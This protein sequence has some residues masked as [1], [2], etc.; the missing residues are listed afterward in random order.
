MSDDILVQ[1]VDYYRRRAEEYDRT[2]YPDLKASAERIDR[3]VA[4]LAPAGRI[5]EL[6]CGTGMWTRALARHSE[7]VTALDASQE[8]MRIARERCPAHV[9]FEVAD[10]FSWRPTDEFDVVFFGFWLSH[11]PTSALD[12]FLATATSAVAPGGRLL[13]VDEHVDYPNREMWSDEPEIAIRELTDGS[14]HPMVKVF[15]D[16]GDLQARLARLGWA[17]SFDIDRAWLIA[18]AHR[19]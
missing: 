15:L 13:F 14:R 10:L 12:A 18:S 1:Q 19:A 11:V 8:P 5:L 16:P 6:A 7:Q 9:R 4:T 3:V 17:V 2:A